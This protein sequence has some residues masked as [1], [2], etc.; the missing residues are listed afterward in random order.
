MSSDAEGLLA[1]AVLLLFGIAHLLVF[2]A[3]GAQGWFVMLIVMFIGEQ[4]WGVANGKNIIWS[5]ISFA[6]CWS[7]VITAFQTWGAP[8]AIVTWIVWC[9]LAAGIQFGLG[10]ETD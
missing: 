1:I 10:V 3:F 6:L 2:M 5:T 4:I 8:G 9:V 7:F